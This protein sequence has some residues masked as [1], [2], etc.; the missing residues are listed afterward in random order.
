MWAVAWKEGRQGGYLGGECLVYVLYSCVCVYSFLRV[1][2]SEMNKI[3][4]S[5][6]FVLCQENNFFTIATNKP[7]HEQ[8]P[9]WVVR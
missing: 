8:A 2:E 4:V 3:R 5:S 1:L 6:E 9:I 7:N